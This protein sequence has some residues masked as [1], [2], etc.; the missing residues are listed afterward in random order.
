[1]NFY[2]TTGNLD[3]EPHTMKNENL[4]QQLG[5]LLNGDLS[6]KISDVWYYKHPL[7]WW[8]FTDRYLYHAFIV[9][10]T[11]NFW[12]TIER[13]TRANITS[14]LRKLSVGRGIRNCNNATIINK[15]DNVG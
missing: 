7:K 6:E 4:L 11:T 10:K 12:F 14:S 1:M 2:F 3:A 15:S 13:N 9:L 8:Q 5:I